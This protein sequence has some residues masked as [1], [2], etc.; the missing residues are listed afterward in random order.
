MYL[1]FIR[2]LNR[3][4]ADAESA[5]GA[6]DEPGGG[7]AEAA[8]SLL[9]AWLRS[10]LLRYAEPSAA[11]VSSGRLREEAAAHEAALGGPVPEAF[12]GAVAAQLGLR[13]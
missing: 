2:L 3:A 5:G 7:R 4:A 8:S 6:M 13:L 12:S 10:A 9:A 1:G 11:L